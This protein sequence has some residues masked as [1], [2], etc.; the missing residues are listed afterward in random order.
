M[1]GAMAELGNLILSG[2][3]FFSGCS[4]S[5]VLNMLRHS[6][7]T[8]FSDRTYN[9]IQSAYLVKAV[10]NVWNKAQTNLFEEARQAGA[11][12]NLLGDGRYDSPGHNAKYLLYTMI[13]ALSGKILISKLV[14]VRL[15]S[16][17]NIA[18]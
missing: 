3:I 5:N 6:K 1:A 2:A 17:N 4:P 16:R 10:H 14:Q 7:V 18:T 13:N 9:R 15:K 8:C 11:R 12:L